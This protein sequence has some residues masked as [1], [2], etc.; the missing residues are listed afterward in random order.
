MKTSVCPHL[1]EAERAIWPFPTLLTKIS[2][3]GI[4]NP[5]YFPLPTFP[6]SLPSFPTHP[7]CVLVFKESRSSLCCS[8]GL[9]DVWSSSA[10]GEPARSC[11]LRETDA[12]PAAT[13][14]KGF[15]A[16]GG[17]W[18]CS[19]PCHWY[20][21]WL[22]PQLLQFLGATALLCLES[23]IFVAITASGS[24]SL[25]PPTHPQWS[26]ILGR[27]DCVIYVPRRA[28]HFS[29]LDSAFWAVVTLSVASYIKRK[30][31]WWGLKD[32][33]I[34][35]C[36]DKPLEVIA[37]CLQGHEDLPPRPVRTSSEV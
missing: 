28:G 10:A 21:I 5:L 13:V 8:H 2:P 6:R 34:C 32:T 14:V 9:S 36:I 15:S 19:S 23:G 26:L 17:T 7:F 27:K 35:G 4:L 3:L 20:C 33:V 18:C 31:L 11:K 12:L 29:P 30:F 1:T 24:Q 16:R 25:C 37:D 22:E